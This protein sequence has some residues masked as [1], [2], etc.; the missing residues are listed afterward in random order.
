[1]VP[2]GSDEWFGF[3]SSSKTILDITAAG[4]IVSGQ[5]G[6]A[7]QHQPGC[8][9]SFNGLNNGLAYDSLGTRRDLHSLIDH[10]H[11]NRLS[12]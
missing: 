8:D 1:M 7:N 3:R 6:W 5:H 9:L 4:M 2:A 11:H 12:N 10:C